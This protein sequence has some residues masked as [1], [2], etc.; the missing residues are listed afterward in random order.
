MSSTNPITCTLA[1]LILSYNELVRIK[2]RSGGIGGPWGMFEST[3]LGF[4]FLSSIL[5]LI[6]LLLRKW[7]IQLI[8]ASRR[9]I[10]D[11]IFRRKP[12]C[13]LSKASLISMARTDVTRLHWLFFSAWLTSFAI[14]STVENPLHS[15]NWC[16]G[17]VSAVHD[18]LSSEYILAIL[19]NFIL[20]CNF[21]ILRE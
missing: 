11:I 19:F 9:F 3:C 1:S 17:M 20:F 2:N 12:L 8:D 7:Y 4:V 10:S 18:P 14:A 15:P 6:R 16:L 13:T 21:Q 5:K